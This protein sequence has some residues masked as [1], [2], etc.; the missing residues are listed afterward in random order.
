MTGRLDRQAEFAAAG[1]AAPAGSDFVADFFLCGV[2]GFI[3]PPAA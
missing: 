2:W 3:G 1:A